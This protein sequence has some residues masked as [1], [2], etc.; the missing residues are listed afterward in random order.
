MTDRWETAPSRAGQ[1][2]R[3]VRSQL[4]VITKMLIAKEPQAKLLYA[5]TS[6]SM[7]DAAGDGAL[8][9]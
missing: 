3:R 5:L 9:A 1:V 4:E 2:F 8:S 6:P 7:C